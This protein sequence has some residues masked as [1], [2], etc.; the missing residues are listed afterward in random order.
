MVGEEAVDALA[1]AEKDAKEGVGSALR[2]T[3]G[4]PES[5][6][7]EDSVEAE[8]VDGAADSEP[9]P[10]VVLGRFV[11]DCV[12]E[13]DSVTD[14]VDCTDALAAADSTAL[15]DANELLDCGLS[16]TVGS[17]DAE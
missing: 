15:A 14:S 8:L 1:P 4:V 10:G 5:E 3:R 13:V 17:G 2:E 11:A 7:E 16:V 6:L 9:T 12:F